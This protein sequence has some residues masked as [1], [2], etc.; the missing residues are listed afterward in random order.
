MSPSAAVLVAQPNYYRGSAFTSRIELHFESIKRCGL[1]QLHPLP[2]SFAAAG[3]G[4]KGGSPSQHYIVY[5]FIS[6]M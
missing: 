1:R 4:F 2:F 3:R 6:L 5:V